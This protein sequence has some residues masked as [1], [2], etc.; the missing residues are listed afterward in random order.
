M[1]SDDLSSATWRTSTYSGNS[2]NCVEIA[3]NLPGLVAIRDSKDPSGGALVVG[4]EEW[5]KFVS[6]IA[7]RNAEHS[8]II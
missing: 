2:G 1:H 6:R 7:T 8:I 4:R 5:Q 3:T